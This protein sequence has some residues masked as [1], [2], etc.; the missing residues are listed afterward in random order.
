MNTNTKIE[1]FPTKKAA[2][3][4]AES[5][6]WNLVDNGS[7]AEKG[8]RWAV[9]IMTGHKP[10]LNTKAATVRNIVKTMD[11]KPRKDVLAA[12]TEATGLGK[13]ATSTYYYNAKTALGL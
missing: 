11:G 8:E 5:T 6:G 2:K 10:R 9:E 4:Y 13:A 7:E 1:F 3:A 12:I